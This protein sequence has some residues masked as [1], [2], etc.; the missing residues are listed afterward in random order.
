MINLRQY[1]TNM[2]VFNNLSY[3]Y[4]KINFQYC[5]FLEILFHMFQ[6]LA[7]KSKIGILIYMENMNIKKIKIFLMLKQKPLDIYME[8]KL[9]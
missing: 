1:I 8:K 4:N 3:N 7:K 9:V 5:E 2:F 6:Y